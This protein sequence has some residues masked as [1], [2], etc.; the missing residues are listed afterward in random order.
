[1]VIC[2][3]KYRLQDSRRYNNS[4]LSTRNVQY[5][6]F[7]HFGEYGSKLIKI[8]IFYLFIQSHLFGHLI[9]GSKYHQMVIFATITL[10]L[11]LITNCFTNMRLV[12]FFA[13][14]S[15]V[16]LIIGA[17]VIIQYTVRQIIQFECKSHYQMVIQS[18]FQTTQPMEDVACLHFIH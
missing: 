14:I 15:S 11:I 9:G 17:I 1:M 13:I 5:R 10:V 2:K 16:F 4:L 12:A 6:D 8:N 3:E 7:V 18:I